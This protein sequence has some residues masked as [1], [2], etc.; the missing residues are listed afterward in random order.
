MKIKPILEF[1]N[2]RINPFEK[3]RTK[4][5]GLQRLKEL[6]AEHAGDGRKA[7]A[8]IIHANRPEEAEN[9]LQELKAEHPAVEFE[10][11]YFGAVIGTH[12]GEGTLG[13]GWYQPYDAE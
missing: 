1:S 11:V 8:F 9:L 6:F 5:K 10:V 3:I 7:K 2:Q 13:I 4:K 12:V